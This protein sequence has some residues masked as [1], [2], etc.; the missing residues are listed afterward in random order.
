MKW[1]D[2]VVLIT[3]ASSGLGKSLAL[4]AGEL[5]ATV[6]LI[7]RNEER[8]KAVSRKI[9]KSFYFSF[10]LEN[11][12]EISTLYKKI[13]DKVG[14]SPTILFNCVGYQFEGFIHEVP[15]KAYERILKVNTLAPVALIQCVLP[16]MVKQGR[17]VIANVFSPMY[18]ALPG[19][20]GPC[21]SKKALEAIHESLKSEVHG[22]PIK[23][24]YIIPG[25]MRTNVWKN[26]K[27]YGIKR[28]DFPNDDAGRNPYDISKKIFDA[29]EQ[30]K[31]KFTLIGFDSKLIRHLN[32]WAPSLLDR[33]IVYK[34]REL[35]KYC[36][37][38]I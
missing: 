22:L 13:V 29:I 37:R 34:K 27:V 3:G 5:G 32:Y 18:H 33:V 1:K 25:T 12:E 24:L 4:R 20:S 6:I 8:L 2:E 21:A 30:G 14:K 23:T 16:D 9:T 17:G 31:E 35:L 11:I 36:R 10:D 38:F 15:I 7:S 28:K 26:T 19:F